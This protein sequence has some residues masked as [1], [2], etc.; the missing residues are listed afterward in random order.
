M[1]ASSIREFI[2]NPGLG[3]SLG[4]A[5]TLTVTPTLL[6]KPDFRKLIQGHMHDLVAAREI[7]YNR[8]ASGF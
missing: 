6:L 1:S 8:V 7:R 5:K 2:R 4:V 3:M